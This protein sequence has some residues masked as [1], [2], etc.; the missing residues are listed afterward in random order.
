[1]SI[2]K[3]KEAIVQHNDKKERG[4]PKLTQRL[5]AS[6]VILEHEESQ[7]ETYMSHWCNDKSLSYLKPCHIIQICI[8][9]GVSPNFLFGW[10][11]T[12]VF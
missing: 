11:E 2:L 7:A 1:M 8:E 10:E 9:T 6:R 3:I 12:N 5:L 4:E